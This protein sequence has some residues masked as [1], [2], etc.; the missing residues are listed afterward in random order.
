WVV[1][2]RVLEPL[3]LLN[4]TARTI[5][6]TDLTQRILVRGDDELA[7][8]ARTFNEM[9]DRLQQ[10]FATQRAFIDDAGHELRTPITIIRG[11]LEVSGDDPDEWQG[12]KP[13]V[14]DELDRMGR[15]VDDMLLLAKAEQPD[16]LQLGPIDLAEFTEEVAAKV[17]PLAD[18]DWKLEEKAHVVI[19][20]DRQR[21]TQAMVNLARN[22]V[23][24]TA[25]GDLIA[26]G[27]SANGGAARIWVRDQ[28]PGVALDQHDLIFKRFARGRGS[29]RA[30]DGAGLGLSIVRAIAETHGGR[31]ELTSAPGFGATFML[32]LP[33]ERPVREEPT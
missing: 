20:A 30:S 13:L 27:S 2:G 33:F 25:P 17:R 6:E 18:R 7:G 15:I 5:T 12:A 10:A 28:G 24:H 31:V 4:Q 22:A 8:L 11:N 29:R 32:V 3:R 16:F 21:L 19:D 1:A 9:L 14:L 26:L 23:Q